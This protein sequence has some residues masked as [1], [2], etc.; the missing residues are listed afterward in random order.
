MI[1][2][3]EESRLVF[4]GALSQR[5]K[6]LGE[7][8]ERDDARANANTNANLVLITR[9]RVIIETGKTG[10]RRR[11][12]SESVCWLGVLVQVLFAFPLWGSGKSRAGGVCA[13]SP[14]SLT[15][16][17]S[18]V[19]PPHPASALPPL[20]SGLGSTQII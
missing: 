12:G 15:R 6:G 9:L 1:I 8:R 4:D 16:L 5:H 13:I 11:D 14:V 20:G 19:R 2:L 7:G 17:S 10:K 3:E 18:S